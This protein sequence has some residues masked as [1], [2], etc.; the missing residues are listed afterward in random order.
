MYLSAHHG[1]FNDDFVKLVEKEAESVE[2]SDG[3]VNVSNSGLQ[4]EVDKELR[5][6][7]VR[8]LNAPNIRNALW[9]FV[10]RVNAERYGFDVWNVAD[11][12][13]TEYHAE[14]EGHYDWHTDDSICT[15]EP[16]FKCRKLSVIVQLSDPKDYR[17]GQFE[18]QNISLPNEIKEKGTILVFPSWEWHRITPVRHGVRKSLVAWFEGP[19]W[20]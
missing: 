15:G 4:H 16:R 1:F 17:G 7:K 6:S 3:S 10:S 11:L 8:F 2:A 5:R 13:Y 18:M 20:R 14:N 12:Q 9:E 19:N